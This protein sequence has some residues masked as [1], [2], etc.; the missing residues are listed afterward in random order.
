[1][2]A[3]VVDWGLSKLLMEPGASHVSTVVKGTPGYINPE[4]VYKHDLHPLFIQRFTLNV[5]V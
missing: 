2:V 5:Q 4:H 1:M 3:K